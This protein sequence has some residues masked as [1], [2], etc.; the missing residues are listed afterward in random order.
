MIYECLNNVNIL[1]VRIIE[2]KLNISVVHKQPIV[3]SSIF[4][5]SLSNLLERVGECIIVG[6]FNTNILL[7]NNIY[8]YPK[9]K[10]IC[11]SQQSVCQSCDSY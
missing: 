8:K 6:D 4:L 7:K 1:T 2:L 10:W 9:S 3:N 5:D 11:Y